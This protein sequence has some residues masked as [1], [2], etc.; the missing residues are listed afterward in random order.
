MTYATIGRAVAA[1]VA[2]GLP[3]SADARVG[4]SGR[5]ADAVG[6]RL[7]HRRRAGG[8]RG[9]RSAGRVSPSPLRADRRAA[10]IEIET[11][12][13]E[14]IPACVAL[15]AHPDDARYQSLFGTEVITPLFGVRVPV[16]AH[17]LADPEKGSG[18][19]MICTFGDITDVTWWRELESAGPRHPPA[20]RHP[21]RRSRGARRAGSRP[22]SR[23]RSRLRRARRPLG[24][25]SAR[26]DCRAAARLGRDG[27]R[28]A[29][30]HPRGEV[31]RKGRPA[32]RDH[33]QP[34]VVHQ[35]HGRSRG[36]AGA[37][38]AS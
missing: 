5:G 26:Q 17:P 7:P 30:D 16:L 12:R 6:H 15:V 14:L 3:A 18:I 24:L 23:G 34:P 37:R 13:P 22:M 11:T 4:L 29:A 19:A 9:P 10:A 28:T 21:A 33:D 31:L 8:A 36:A 35:D 2:A 32:A 27:R 1:R 38:R 20:R 25:E